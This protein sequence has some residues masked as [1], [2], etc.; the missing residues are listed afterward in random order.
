MSDKNL[1]GIFYC[2]ISFYKQTDVRW[3]HQNESYELFKLL[4]NLYLCQC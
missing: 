2:K 4:D 1:L 3:F